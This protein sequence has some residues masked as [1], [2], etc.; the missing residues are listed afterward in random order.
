MNKT[1]STIKQVQD[2]LESRQNT[3]NLI[4]AL[5]TILLALGSILSYFPSF[6]RVESI[7][8]SL[9]RNTT[10]LI[11]AAVFVVIMWGLFRLIFVKSPD[12]LNERNKDLLLLVLIGIIFAVGIFLFVRYLDAPPGEDILEK[13]GYRPVILAP[14]G[15]FGIEILTPTHYDNTH[16]MADQKIAAS[17]RLIPGEI[18]LFRVRHSHEAGAKP[19]RCE[20]CKNREPL[21]GGEY[22]Y[23]APMY[24]GAYGI[25]LVMSSKQGNPVSH[26]IQVFVEEIKQASP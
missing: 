17:I 25:N 7:A 20:E 4:A 26:K 6:L 19:I 10:P 1:M 8:E 12:W 15:S 5:L 24:A 22:Q 21:K 11:V 18:I 9:S 3:I 16:S 2:F 14:N 23:R 13:H